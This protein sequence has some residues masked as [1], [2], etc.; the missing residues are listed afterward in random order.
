MKYKT[1]RTCEVGLFPGNI[2]IVVLLCFFFL[3]AWLPF[4]FCLSSSV[5]SFITFFFVLKYTARHFLFFLTRNCTASDC[6]L[7]LFEK[8]F[9]GQC[10]AHTKYP[11][12]IIDCVS[13]KTMKLGERRNGSNDL[14]T[15]SQ[16][17]LMRGSSRY[18]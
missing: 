1:K 14:Q 13:S 8:I 12:N 16:L 15:F 7:S 2:F 4:P 6:L 5:N 10:L 11:L 9:R 3:P 18:A 17:Q